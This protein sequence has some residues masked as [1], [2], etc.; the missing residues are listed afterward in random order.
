MVRDENDKVLKHTQQHDNPEPT[1]THSPISPTHP[2]HNQPISPELTC[3]IDSGT[4]DM[5]V[6]GT[7]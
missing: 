7:P 5:S 6:P 4:A 1:L 3:S 2:S